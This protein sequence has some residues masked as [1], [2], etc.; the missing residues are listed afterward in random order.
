ME[1]GEVEDSV[2]PA[3]HDDPIDGRGVTQITVDR[4]SGRVDR[5]AM[6]PGEVIE[7]D[8]VV[9]LLDQPLDCHTS[10]VSTAAGDKDAH[11]PSRSKLSTIVFGMV[12]YSIQ[13]ACRFRRR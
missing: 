6:T 12:A 5:R 1:R 4:R 10:D 11:I 7:R 13:R 2:C 8:N 9:S 3:V